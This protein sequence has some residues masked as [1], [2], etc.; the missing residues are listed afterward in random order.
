MIDL[1]RAYAPVSQRKD[2]LDTLMIAHP[3]AG[4]LPSAILGYTDRP[5]RMYYPEWAVAAA[6]G[7]RPPDQVSPGAEI[8]PPG[9][10]EAR[11][12]EDS[13][14]TAAHDPEPGP[15]DRGDDRRRLLGAAPARQPR[16]DDPLDL[17][18][19]QGDR[20]HRCLPPG[21][22]SRPGTGAAH[23]LGLRRGEMDRGR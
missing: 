23:L 6:G 22:A 20:A 16:A 5:I 1:K 8:V 14:G 18:P 15:A 12:G 3:E 2:R 10:R 9:E 11:G 4:V 19:V 13:Y 21:L 17:P 7:G